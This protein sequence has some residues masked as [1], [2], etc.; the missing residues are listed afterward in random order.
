ML[1]LRS[2]YGFGVVLGSAVLVVILSLTIIK[3]VTATP[4][5]MPDPSSEWYF[6]E[7]TEYYQALGQYNNIP[8]WYIVGSVAGFLLVVASTVAYFVAKCPVCGVLTNVTAKG[9]TSLGIKNESSIGPSLTLRGD[10]VLTFGSKRVK[11]VQSWRVRTC[12]N[13]GHHWKQPGLTRELTSFD[14]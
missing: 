3:N 4:P 14:E 8:W 7:M 10:V 13:C 11:R 5:V 1:F 12:P 2:K 6:S 9:T